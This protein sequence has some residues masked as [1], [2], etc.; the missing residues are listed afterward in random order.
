M[1]LFLIFSQIFTFYINSYPKID[2]NNFERQTWKLD[3]IIFGK[4][5]KDTF[6]IS[7]KDSIYLIS[8]GK[9]RRNKK[10]AIRFDII[11]SS[12]KQYLNRATILCNDISKKCDLFI[13]HY[14]FQVKRT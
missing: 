13:N 7:N 4:T 10:C 14:D 5:K 11:L 9:I 1:I 8:F 2:T 3:K 6:L 12:K